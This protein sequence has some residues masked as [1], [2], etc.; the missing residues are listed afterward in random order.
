MVG[1][2]CKHN[3]AKKITKLDICQVQRIE[4]DYARSKV[5]SY[6]Q[7]RLGFERFV[8]L[9]KEVREIEEKRD[10]LVAKVRGVWVQQD[11]THN[12]QVMR[13][14]VSADLVVQGGDQER[15]IRDKLE[16]DDDDGSDAGSVRLGPFVLDTKTQGKCIWNAMHNSNKMVWKPDRSLE[17]RMYFVW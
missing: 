1:R 14:R 6:V 15:P 13:W 9:N 12:G 10:A 3:A 7:D 8:E 5:L 16:I 17:S 2:W 4:N 11:G